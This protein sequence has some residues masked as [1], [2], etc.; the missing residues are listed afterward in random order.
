MMRGCY[1]LF[2]S[3]YVDWKGNQYGCGWSVIPLNHTKTSKNQE[4]YILSGTPRKLLLLKNSDLTKLH[5]SLS[6]TTSRLFFSFFKEEVSS[7]QSAF[8]Q[9]SLI[10][11]NEI[12]GASERVPGLA[13]TTFNNGKT[14]VTAWPCFGGSISQ[15]KDEDCEVIPSNQVNLGKLGEL[16]M[17]QV[18][19]HFSEGQATAECN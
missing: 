17:S 14:E 12:V 1:Q 13:L 6:I 2:A 5:E 8:S 10:D 3:Q 16:V 9:T 18:K 11:D 15:S 4:A 7:Y 19:V